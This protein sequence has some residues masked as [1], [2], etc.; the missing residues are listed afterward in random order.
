MLKLNCKIKDLNKS[1]KIILLKMN[2][3]QKNINR[4][5]HPRGL[6]GRGMSLL[7]LSLKKGETSL[8]SSQKKDISSASTNSRK[9]KLKSGLSPQKNVG[10]LAL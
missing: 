6:S 1:Y 10:Q 5:I 7:K 3:K 8:A 2:E 9:R 4:K